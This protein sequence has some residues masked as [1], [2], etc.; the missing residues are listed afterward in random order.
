VILG[1][2]LMKTA[3]LIDGAFFIY[4]ARKIFGLLDPQELTKRLFHHCCK[5][6]TKDSRID[7]NLYRI[8]FYDCP[9]LC[10]KLEHPLTRKQIDYST[11]DRAK[12]RIQLHDTLR[13]TPKTA[14]RLGTVD[15]KNYSWIIAD[16]KIRKLCR[17][18]II[19][20][21][22]AENDVT[23]SV[24]QKGVDMRIG[25]DIASMAYKRQVERIVLIAGDSDFVPA[26]KMAR[27]EGIEFVLD[28]MW[29]SI[30]PDL[31]E[32]I[33]RLRSV[34]PKPSGHTLPDDEIA[35]IENSSV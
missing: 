21:D 35:Q 33:D 10:K 9:P 23:L 16:K 19:V 30:K 17:G 26:A 34:F 1:D 6:V 3:I 20:N 4:R 5:H 7:E 32:H 8:F 31:Q 27:R 11:S 13:R 28:P 18:E 29:A 12:W 22:L 15:D 24:K 14:L 2:V 25:L